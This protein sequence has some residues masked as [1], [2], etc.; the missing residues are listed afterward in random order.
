MAKQL[1]DWREYPPLAG[2]KAK[3]AA[4]E[5]LGVKLEAKAD[6]SIQA[7]DNARREYE[8]TEAGQLAGFV[9]GAN[10]EKAG[11]FR[12]DAE[13][14]ESEAVKALRLNARAREL[15]GEHI[16]QYETDGKLEA[17]G[18]IVKRNKE[19]ARRMIDT[20]TQAGKINAELMDLYRELGAYQGV[21]TKV[22]FWDDLL[23]PAQPGAPGSQSRLARWL[24][25]AKEYVNG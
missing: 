20:L 10:M 2:A 24:K 5:A 13:A 11:K 6:S 21:G 3:L 23:L 1:T 22:L 17:R 9:I 4:L 25:F 16:L 12:A 18:N 8:D 19:A 14:S 15:L 7:A